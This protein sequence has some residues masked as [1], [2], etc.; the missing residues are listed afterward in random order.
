MINM[1]GEQRWSREVRQGSSKREEKILASVTFSY[2]ISTGLFW[3]SIA[4]GEPGALYELPDKKF[5]RNHEKLGM[6]AEKSARIRFGTPDID[7]LISDGFSAVDMH[8]HTHYSDG[9]PS[10]RQILTHVQKRRIGI[11]ITDHNEVR[12]VQEMQASN[13]EA[14]VIPGIELD[15]AE[16][17]HLLLY[18]YSCTDLVD[19]FD[20]H[21]RDRR[22]GAQ[23]TTTS[24]P[25][26]QILSFA[27]GYSCLKVAAHPFG[28]FCLNRGILKCEAKNLLQGIMDRL[29]G[30][31]AICGGMTRNVNRMAVEYANAHHIPV[32]GG[33]DAHILQEIGSVITGVRADS[34]GDFLDGIKRG[35]S[36]VVGSS[37]GIAS[38]V[39]TGSVIAYHYVPY[40]VNFLHTRIGLHTNRLKRLLR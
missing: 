14:L 33:S 31:E 7:E 9:A 39:M 11:A 22:V 13:S 3:H 25:T 15:C 10:L 20:R 2:S 34:V 17:P 24:L 28:Y 35:E 23:Y 6:T 16:G 30:I 4:E 21:I 37:S 27:E 26:A 5:A 12:G 36:I 29:D 19:F 1:L 18:F 38:R 8:V 32:T 40:S